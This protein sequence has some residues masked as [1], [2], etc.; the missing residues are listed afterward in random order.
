VNLFRTEQPQTAPEPT[1][2]MKR[3]R[4][5]GQ[6]IVIFAG[7]MLAFM[8]LM[9]IVID[10]SWYW[11]NT[12]RVQ[13]AADAAAL[14]GV[15]WLPNLY[16]SADT[17]ARAEA[18][19]NGYTAGV[20][21][22]AI[23]TAKDPNNDRKLIVTISTSIPS[24]FARVI[25][26]ASF[27]I[28][29]TSK[30]E[31]ILPVAMGSPENYY[32]VFGDIRKATF[33]GPTTTDTGFKAATAI[34]AATKCT[35]ANC[36]WTTTSNLFNKTVATNSNFSSS[37]TTAA[38]QQAWSQ[39]NF[40]I[41]GGA[42]INGIEVQLVAKLGGGTAGTTCYIGV[43]LSP[44]G[45]TN[46]YPAASNTAVT[47][48]LATVDGTFTIGTN[49]STAPWTVHAWVPA[50]FG[51][52]G[53]TGF[54]AR[55]T[56]NRGDCA[57]TRFAMVDTLTVRVTYTTVSTSPQA[58]KALKGPGSTCANGLSDC[59]NPDG[60]VLNYHGFWGTMNTEG[61]ANVNG[62]AFQPYY[63]TPTSK[64]SPAC[65][66]ATQRACYDNI[67]YY[68][69]AID[70]PAGSSGGLVYIFDPVFCATQL[71]AGVGDRWF[72]GNNPV[73][74]W[75]ELYNT[76]NTPYNL[77]DDTLITTSG[78]KFTN[79]NGSDTSMGG[80]GGQL[81]CRQTNT[82]YGDGRDYHD[83]W[84]LLNPGA[85]L[86]GG[87]NGTI[88]RLH[89]TST[90]PSNGFAQRNANGEQS[91]AI[92][93]S[94]SGGNPK[95]YGLGAMQMITPLSSSGG[96]TFSDLYLAQV[97]AAHAGK[98]LEIS[99]WDPGDTGP[100]SANLQVEI[101]TAGGWTPVAMNWTAVT[102][103][104]DSNAAPCNSYAPGSGNSIVTNVG[105]GAGG[106]YNGC[107][108]TIDVTIPSTYT[109]PQSGWWKMRYNM[110]GNGT[111]SD[112]TTWTAKIRGNPVHLVLP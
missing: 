83:S 8:G 71:D 75:Y 92:F 48:N 5:R 45:G 65:P 111:S 69:Y 86:S 11:A 36:D 19:K 76:N 62:D 4:S 35:P 58:D 42:T 64:V 91:F 57:A 16:S 82:V 47:T 95:V 85:P 24:F 10:V 27:P 52:S 72:G 12:L 1:L 109:A 81:E 44:N 67:N 101:P 26:V 30:A 78:A 94:A 84:W 55:T 60:A 46:W 43:Q 41:P 18:T 39:W 14:A 28:A 13:R 103:T 93:A 2:A 98:T 63:D 34:P 6:V 89:T 79:L 61:A 66:T 87:P 108:L 40:G 7:A 49:A 100:L 112:V 31:F 70:M 107:W 29:R 33:T 105:G 51:N 68:N 102:G 88:Y 23:T 22:T 38:S 21:N 50:D 99:L 106:V 96:S 54:M 90:D 15:V 97:P 80:P 104:A 74:S 3:R 56:W 73:S 25:G 9:A 110:S 37:T 59:L 77:A 53:A 32:G 20:N 17:T